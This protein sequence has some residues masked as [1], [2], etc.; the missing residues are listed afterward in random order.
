MCLAI[1]LKSG[2]RTNFCVSVAGPLA[3]SVDSYDASFVTVDVSTC[4]SAV[5]NQIIDIRIPRHGCYKLN[6][7]TCTDTFYIKNQQ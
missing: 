6:K 1:M 3:S 4:I 2:M 7:K 5:A